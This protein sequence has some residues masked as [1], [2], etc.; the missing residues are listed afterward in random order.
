MTEAEHQQR[1]RSIEAETREIKQRI[2]Q[3]EFQ[4][5]K[6]VIE[7]DKRFKERDAQIQRQ[8]D[9]LIKIVG[10]TYEELDN[11]DYKIQETGRYL[12]Q[13]RKHSTIS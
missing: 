6:D 12:I 8:L 13:P 11:L 2:M 4:H 5:K 1:L 7:G 10:I 3:L 9:H